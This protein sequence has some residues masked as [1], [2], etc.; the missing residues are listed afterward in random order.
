MANPTEIIT[1][2]IVLLQSNNFTG[3]PDHKVTILN[4][5]GRE[6]AF[7]CTPEV[8]AAIAGNGYTHN[9][10]RDYTVKLDDKGTITD[11]IPGVARVPRGLKLAVLAHNSEPAN[12]IVFRRD[13]LSSGKYSRLTPVKAP[14]GVGP[15][16][17]ETLSASLPSRLLG[18][19]VGHGY[20]LF[21]TIEQ[22]PGVEFSVLTK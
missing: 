12:C 14:M 19:T 1:E 7:D 4:T 15:E 3:K 16:K 13:K 10:N 6:K 2:N 21:R 20:K 18:E 5:D 9:K 11:I 17:L 8:A 22:D